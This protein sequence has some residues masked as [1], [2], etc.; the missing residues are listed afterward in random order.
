[1]KPLAELAV[2]VLS[3]ADGRAKTALSRA[4]AET[5]RVARAEGIEY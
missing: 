4:H 1:M 2:E 5:W 3:T